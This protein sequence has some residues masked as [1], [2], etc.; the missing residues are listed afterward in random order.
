MAESIQMSHD[1]LEFQIGERTEELSAALT[2]L[3][4]AQEELIRKEKLATLGQV[5]G[6]IAH[7]LRNPLGVMTN[8]L[9]YLSTVLE[10]APPKVREHL[11]KV[12]AQVRLSESIINGL[13]SFT[14]S[15]P[16]SVEHVD[17]AQ[18][19]DEQLVRMVLPETVTVQRDV[20][21][22]IPALRADP[23]HVAQILMNLLTNAVQA[24]GTAGVLSI[25]ARP[26]ADR[27]RIEVSDSGPGIAA[28]NRER[29]FEPLFTT[30]ARGIGLGLSVSRT[31][32]QANGGTLQVVPSASGSGATIAL[33]LPAVSL[34]R[35]A[36]ANPQVQGSTKMA[37]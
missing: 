3:Q 36:Q 12:R 15:G 21:A 24:I 30:K 37:I 27:V 16:P 29:I 28:E 34:V 14:R 9:F 1:T 4:E 20:P 33:E 8:A 10:D 25:R 31:L 23:V 11:A 35:D 19:I 6:S 7:E 32:A 5:S 22:D 2:R 17:A 13:L 26:V 18:L